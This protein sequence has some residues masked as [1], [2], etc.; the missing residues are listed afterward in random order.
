MVNRIKCLLKNKEGFT[1]IYIILVM[2]VLLPIMLFVFIDLPHLMTM[3]R[4]ADNVIENA[5]ATA[6]T[7]INKSKA[8]NGVL[9]INEDEAKKKAMQIIAQTYNLNDDLSLNEHSTLSAPPKIDIEVINNPSVK[10][11][12]TTPNG[13]FAIKNPSVVIYGEIPVNGLIWKYA[14]LT[15]KHTGISQVQF[16]TN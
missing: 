9:Y 13:T 16:R 15:A 2:S 7:Y 14:K 5:S 11:S 12:I 8:S 3:D 10:D 6:I 1:A 4:R